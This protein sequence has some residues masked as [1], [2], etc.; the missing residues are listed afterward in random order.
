MMKA[1]HL[2]ASMQNW[3]DTMTIDQIER[4]QL[5]EKTAEIAV[6]KVLAERPR[7]PHVNRGQAA[8]M[9]GVSRHTVTEYI[10]H[11]ILT[12]NDFGLIPITEVDKAL[13]GNPAS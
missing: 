12:V 8:E 4:V 13:R 11:G 1:V 6:R 7:P 9:L 2:I 3:R 10:R 5:A